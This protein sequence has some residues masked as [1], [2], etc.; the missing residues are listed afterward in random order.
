MPAEPKQELP[1]VEGF[2]PSA[3]PAQ[4]LPPEVV[5]KSFSLDDFEVEQLPKQTP[6]VKEEKKIEV[7]ETTPKVE[8]KE[9][10]SEGAES[11]EEVTGEGEGE[12]TPPAK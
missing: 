10:K 1:R 5:D 11:K 2:K 8:V 7:K 4:E 3:A 12:E 6:E 9:T